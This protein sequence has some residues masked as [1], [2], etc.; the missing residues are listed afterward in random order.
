MFMAILRIK[1]V[2]EMD[3]SALRN[4]YNDIKKELINLNTNSRVSGKN[5][6]TGHIKE[7][8]KTLARMLTVLRERGAL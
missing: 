3:D 1:E 8:R 4:K 5:I 6:N 7:M 2:R